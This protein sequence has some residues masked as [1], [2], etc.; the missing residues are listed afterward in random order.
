MPVGNDW[1]GPEPRDFDMGG[2]DWVAGD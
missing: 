2:A 1:L